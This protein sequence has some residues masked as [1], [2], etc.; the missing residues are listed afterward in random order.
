M[1]HTNTQEQIKEAMRAR[2]ALRLSVLRGLLAAF[3]NEVVAKKRKPSELL[4]DEEAIAVIKRAANQRKDSI[5]QFKKGNRQDLAN[6]E[7][8][9]LKILDEYLPV[10]LGREDIEKVAKAKKEALGIT[11][12]KDIG[13]LVGEVMKEL[14]N[15]ADGKDVKEVIEFLLSSTD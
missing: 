12:K 9:E 15:K 8:A 1:I 4:T 6:K 7:T 13:R 10:Q 5:E 2:D 3:T 11:D 14:K